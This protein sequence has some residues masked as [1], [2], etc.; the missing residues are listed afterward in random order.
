MHHLSYIKVKYWQIIDTLPCIYF[1]FYT[2]I[3]V[4]VDAY[5]MH[6]GLNTTYGKS[7]RGCDWWLNC[8]YQPVYVYRISGNLLSFF[9]R[10]QNLCWSEIKAIKKKKRPADGAVTNNWM[11]KYDLCLLRKDQPFK[12][13]SPDMNWPLHFCLALQIYVECQYVKSC[14]AFPHKQNDVCFFNVDFNTG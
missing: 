4:I 5:E 2:K 6:Y 8:F 3:W 11:Q 7:P 1:K 12:K 9:F 13:K 14:F 10:T